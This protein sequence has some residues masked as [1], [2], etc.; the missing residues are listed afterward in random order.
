VAGALVAAGLALLMATAARAGD[1]PDPNLTPGAVA[2]TNLAEVCES[3]GR[4]MMMA[5]AEP[6]SPDTASRGRS[7][8]GT[9]TTTWYRSASAVR[10]R[11]RTAG[12]SPGGAGGV[13]TRRTSWKATPVAQCARVNSTFVRRRAGFTRRPTGGIPTAAFS[14]VSV[15]VPRPPAS[16]AGTIGKVHRDFQTRSVALADTWGASRC[17]ARPL[18]PFSRS[19]SGQS[20]ARGRQMLR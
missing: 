10:T 8:A 3:D 11:R 20:S 14:A 16:V 4:T 17:C 2:S 7:A 9:R 6:I 5:R 19:P 18:S 13:P 12:L 15:R 1:V